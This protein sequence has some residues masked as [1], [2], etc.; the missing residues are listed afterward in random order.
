MVLW[1]INAVATNIHFVQRAKEAR[2][3]G[4]RILLIE[5]YANDTAAAPT[6]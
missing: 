6:R 2:R 3:R 1:G 4:G 5:T